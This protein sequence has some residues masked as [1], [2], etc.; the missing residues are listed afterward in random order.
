MVIQQILKNQER[1]E[2]LLRLIIPVNKI[3]LDLQDS[4]T[5][6]D[7]RSKRAALLMERF[8][9]L[10][11]IT[12]KQKR[13]L[14]FPSEILPAENERID[15]VLFSTL[16]NRLSPLKDF[17][18]R[19]GEASAI[20][21]IE[22]A[23]GLSGLVD[24]TLGECGLREGSRTR[25]IMTTEEWDGLKGESRAS[26]ND[27]EESREEIVE[28]LSKAEAT[29]APK[30][31]V[32]DDSEESEEETEPEDEILTGETFEESE[33]AAAISF[34][35]GAWDDVVEPDED[36]VDLLTDPDVEEPVTDEHGD[37]GEWND[38]EE[39]GDQ[40]EHHPFV[41]FDLAGEQAPKKTSLGIFRRI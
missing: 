17:A 33:A 4:D 27:S 32:W 35:R 22:T 8:G 40:P 26:K 13:S 6:Y 10:C 31:A 39:E 20:D 38:Y 23:L 7:I 21:N 36:V 28:A 14:R 25:V 1:I 9:N 2:R 29:P 24:T 18:K 34:D 12:G 19:P 30:I 37:A 15:I 41:D 3:P 16:L 11:A 5:I